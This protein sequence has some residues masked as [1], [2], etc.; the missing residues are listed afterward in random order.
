MCI[1]L[2][3]QCGRV[4]LSRGLVC[5]NYQGLARVGELM[6]NRL[7][8]VA[9]DSSA[10]GGLQSI[11]RH[12]ASFKNTAAKDMDT[13]DIAEAATPLQPVNSEQNAWAPFR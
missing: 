3:L 10:G 11:P 6:D 13:L 2:S 7:S 9:L 5:D 8:V 4:R 12:Y 1:S